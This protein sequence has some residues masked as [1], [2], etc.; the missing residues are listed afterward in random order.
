VTEPEGLFTLASWLSLP[1]WV[2][3]VV[4]PRWRWSA[5]IIGPVI[6]PMILSALYI[7][8]I[9]LHL[10]HAQ[11][12]FGSLADVRLLF[13]EDWLLLA[14][15]IHYLAFDLFIGSWEVRDAQRIGIPHLIVVP[16]LVLTLFVGPIGF[17]SYLLA[18][19]AHR[20]VEV[21]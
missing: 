5:R 19:A 15:W 12:G 16:C 4:A 6:L 18:R 2:L 21:D 9:A 20:R 13:A 14:G 1:G 17:L 11:G 10:P 7:A 8:A 3:L